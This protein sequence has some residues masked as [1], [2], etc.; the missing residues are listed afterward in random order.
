MILH[1]SPQLRVPYPGRAPSLSIPDPVPTTQAESGGIPPNAPQCDCNHWPS[2]NPDLAARP[3]WEG[4]SPSPLQS[5]GG[6]SV[7]AL[8]CL[9]R[10]VCCSDNNLISALSRLL[11]AKASVSAENWGGSWSCIIGCHPF[12]FFPH[13]LFCSFY[14]LH[15]CNFS[16]YKIMH[17]KNSNISEM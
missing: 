1:H 5:D 3:L 11:L 9:I 12:S 16:D 6:S 17:S 10:F 13:A 4:L 8:T 14:F 15:V 7:S 2:Y